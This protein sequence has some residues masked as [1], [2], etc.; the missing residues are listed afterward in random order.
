MGRNSR[1]IYLSI[2]KNYVTNKNKKNIYRLEKEAFSL[3]LTSLIEKREKKN[4]IN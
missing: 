3:N 1:F 4:P 2:N